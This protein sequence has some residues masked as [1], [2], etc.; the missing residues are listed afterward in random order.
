MLVDSDAD[1]FCC[2][3]VSPCCIC[4]TCV[5]SRKRRVLTVVSD[6]PL[7]CAALH[8]HPRPL[9]HHVVPAQIIPT[10][11]IEESWKGDYVLILQK[12]PANALLDDLATL[13]SKF[14]HW[15][16]ILPQGITVSV[17]SLPGTI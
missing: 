10:C 14:K 8:E 6:R 13:Y 16:L 12:P 1:L 7:L 11:R 17:P 2:L 9:R 4:H 15:C 5:Y 3:R